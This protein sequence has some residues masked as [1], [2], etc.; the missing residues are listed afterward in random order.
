MTILPLSPHGD[1][2]VWGAV[3][4]ATAVVLSKVLKLISGRLAERRPEAERELLRLRRSETMLV[5]VAT[6]IPYATAIVVI[7]VIASTFLPRTA[8]LGGT[9]FLGIIAGFTIVGDD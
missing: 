8:T 9:A 2:L 3:A 7:V 5:L 1:R 6:A 4:I